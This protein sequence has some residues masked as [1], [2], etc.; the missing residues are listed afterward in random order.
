MEER[1]TIFY[2]LGEG[3]IVKNVNFKVASE[4]GRDSMGARLFISTKDAGIRVSQSCFSSLCILKGRSSYFRKVD[5][6]G[7]NE[8]KGFDHKFEDCR[9]GDMI[10]SGTNTIMS[11]CV[12]VPEWLDMLR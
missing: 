5:V 11:G 10:D 2:M 12:T 6:I 1:V 8:I 7:E 3:N 9:F 4:L